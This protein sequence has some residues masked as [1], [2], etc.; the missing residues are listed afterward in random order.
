MS[1]D[2]FT[3]ADLRQLAALGISPEEAARQIELFRN[4]PPATRI[5]RPCRI[6]DGI[7]LLALD[8]HPTLLAAFEA[9]AAQG[10]IG[11][12]VP[13]SGAATRMFQALLAHLSNEDAEMTGEVRTFYENLHRF[14][15][16]ADN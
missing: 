11:K 14:P 10:R 13:A 6:G 9:A 15:F 5:V 4:P 7:R 16:Q 12:F 3:T 1:A 2:L 8:E